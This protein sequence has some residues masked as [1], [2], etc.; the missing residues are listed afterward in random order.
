[1]IAEAVVTT[2]EAVVTNAEAVVMTIETTRSS[3]PSREVS[4]VQP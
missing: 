2:A 1:M 3:S 4:Q